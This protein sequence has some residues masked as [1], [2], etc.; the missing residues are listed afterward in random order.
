LNESAY[1]PRPLDSREPTS[2]AATEPTEFLDLCCHGP[3][4]GLLAV[5]FD[6]G[7][8]FYYRGFYLLYATLKSQKWE[9][10]RPEQTKSRRGFSEGKPYGT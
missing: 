3:L 4:R 5:Q 7:F 6:L 9:T 1:D 10:N 2:W 8:N